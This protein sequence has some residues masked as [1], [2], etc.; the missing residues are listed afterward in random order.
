MF[1]LNSS[2]QKGFAMKFELVDQIVLPRYGGRSGGI[3]FGA[4]RRGLIMKKN[5]SALLFIRAGYSAAQSGVRGFGREYNPALL[6]LQTPN[7]T[8]SSYYLG[9]GLAEG[10][11]SKS[12]LMEHANKIEEAF[13]MMD[14]LQHVDIKKTLVVE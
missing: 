1:L 10:R 11:I 8:N 3:D 6:Q 2:Q 5:N 14:F 9:V 4:T 13:G 12:K 7:D